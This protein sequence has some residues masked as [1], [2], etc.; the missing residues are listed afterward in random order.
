MTRRL[1]W[2][3]RLTVAGDPQ[4]VLLTHA[5]LLRLR[6]ESPFMH[7]LRYDEARAEVSYWE[8]GADM[9]DAASLALR[10]W[11]EHRLSAALP[12]WKVVGLE[13]VERDTYQ[14]RES[15]SLAGTDAVPQ[16]F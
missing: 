5:A 6:A 1:L 12:D 10:L 15:V 4:D 16:R 11:G 13:V 7:S 2:H 14:A 8:E 9:L 3:V